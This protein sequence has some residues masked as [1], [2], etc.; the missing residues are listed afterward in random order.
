MLG[1]CSTPPGSRAPRSDRRV[2]C[3]L[4]V[5]I[6]FD[7]N[8]RLWRMLPLPVLTQGC[9]H[10]TR[11]SSEDV[12]RNVSGGR[13][14]VCGDEQNSWPSE[15]LQIKT[16]VSYFCCVWGVHGRACLAWQRLFEGAGSTRSATV[17]D[18]QYHKPGSKHCELNQA[19]C[20]DKGR[21]GLLLLLI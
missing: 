17:G 21:S 8:P 6:G 1:R 20:F 14:Y 12:C 19:L 3:Q 15:Q 2:C 18:H 9:R 13:Q 5:V 11:S 4:W 16:H 10:T 7:Y